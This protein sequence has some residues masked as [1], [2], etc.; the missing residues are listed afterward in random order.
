MID[1]GGQMAGVA[2]WFPTLESETRH[3]LQPAAQGVPLGF[4]G[5]RGRGA[6]GEPRTP[7]DGAGGDGCRL[8]AASGRVGRVACGEHAQAGAAVDGE[9]SR[10]SPE[11]GT[12]SPPMLGLDAPM[13]E[14]YAATLA[15]VAAG[16]R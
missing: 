4:R 13:P 6:L 11:R 8:A 15:T 16:H 2:A 9:A 14:P 1:A 12:G 3:R 10:P 5:R 7:R